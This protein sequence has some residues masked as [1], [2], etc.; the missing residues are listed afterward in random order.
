MQKRSLMILSLAALLAAASAWWI[1]GNQ[2][3]SSDIQNETAL[4]PDLLKQI[5][6][7]DRVE[8]QAANESVTLIKGEQG[9]TVQEKSGYPANMQN[10]RKQL[11]AFSEA[12]I[13]ETKTA[14]PENYSQLGVADVAPGSESVLVKLGGMETEVGLLVGNQNYRGQEST[15]V[16]RADQ[17]QSYL[18]SGSLKMDSKASNWLLKDIFNVGAPRV[19]RALIQHADGSVLEIVKN[20]QSDPNF[21]VLSVPEG[22]ELA[23]PGAGN[24]VAGALGSLRL[25]DVEAAAD[26]ALDSEL[27]INGI[28]ETFDGL[29]I[30]TTTWQVADKHYLS[31]AVAFDP[32]LAPAVESATDSENPDGESGSNP[33]EIDPTAAAN[34]AQEAAEMQATVTGW[35]YVIP[36]YKYDNLSKTVFDLLK[37]LPV[38]LPASEG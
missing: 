21:S 27:V 3:P 32:A 37:P 11:I 13:L 17:A 8:I 25:E 16:R 38:E 12:S 30:S 19:R 7:V 26:V 2:Q 9:W 28:F 20:N 14:N 4:F 29:R 31:L 5:N 35:V 23:A 24:S 36:S 33:E 1:T 15:Y 6:Q 34:P 18:V 10:L 22:R